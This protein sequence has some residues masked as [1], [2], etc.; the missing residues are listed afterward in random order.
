MKG[1]EPIVYCF[2]KMHLWGNKSHGFYSIPNHTSWVAIVIQTD[3][4]RSFLNRCVIAAFGVVFMT[5]LCFLDLSVS[6]GEFFIGLSQT[7][8]FFLLL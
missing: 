7:S 5:S 6:V 1:A 2:R 8:S 3:R 4:P